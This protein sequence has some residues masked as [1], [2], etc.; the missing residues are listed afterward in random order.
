MQLVGWDTALKK[1]C[2][3]RH[4]VQHNMNNSN[5]RANAESDDVFKMY[6]D[7]VWYLCST[8]FLCEIERIK[9]N[10]NWGCQFSLQGIFIV[11]CPAC[12]QHATD[13]DLVLC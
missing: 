5:P 9:R 8:K 10:L 1:Q 12:T 11:Q 6:E 4:V 2:Q 7:D 13:M 3:A